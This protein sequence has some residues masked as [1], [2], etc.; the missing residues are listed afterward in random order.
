MIEI[1]TWAETQIANKLGIN[2][3]R[4]GANPQSRESYKSEQATLESSL[5]TTGDIYRTIQFVK[6]RVAITTLLY[7]QDILKFKESIPYKWLLN[8]LGNEMFMSI[9]VLDS[10][11]AHRFGI[12]F[13]DYNTDVNKNNILQAANTALQ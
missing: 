6:Q 1:F 8:L 13:G 2:A 5:N 10:I 4:L 11:A 9:D 12:F 3:M 7:G